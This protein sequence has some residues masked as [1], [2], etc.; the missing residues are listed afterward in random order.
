MKSILMVFIISWWKL[1][2]NLYWRYYILVKI[3]L[4]LKVLYPN[5]KLPGD[6]PCSI[7][8]PGW[9]QLQALPHSSGL[10]DFEDIVR[11]WMSVNHDSGNWQ[12]S[13]HRNLEP[14]MRKRSELVRKEN[15]RSHL[16]S[17]SLLLSL[18]AATWSGYESIVLSVDFFSTSISNQGEDY[19]QLVRGL[20]GG[21]LWELQEVA[22]L[23][24]QNAIF[25]SFC[26]KDESGSDVTLLVY[27]Q[28]IRWNWNKPCHA[29]GINAIFEVFTTHWNWL[30]VLY[31]CKVSPCSLPI[32]KYVTQ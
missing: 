26:T 17:S 8:P 5:G 28:I 10:F 15:R 27:V 30:S 22:S 11:L 4:L 23:V 2:W 3:I 31:A 21:C 20:P 1:Y 9:P 7:H 24:K 16:S 12:R 25:F 19:N 6:G 18:D 14:G 13:H 32:R 29:I